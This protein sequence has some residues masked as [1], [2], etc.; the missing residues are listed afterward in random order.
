M[1]QKTLKLQAPS[2]ARRWLIA[3]GVYNL[4]W[5]GLVILFPH[6][7]FDLTGAERMRYPE[8]WQC[9]GMIVGVYGIGYI[10]ASTNPRQHWPIILVGLLGKVFGPIG[11]AFAL[12]KGTFPPS[13]G[14]TI[15]TND[16]IWWA[17]FFMILWD[18]FRSRTPHP[19]GQTPT[20]DSA[21][22]SLQDQH[23]RTLADTTE[24]SPTLVVLLRHS[25]CTFCKEA[26]ADLAS[27]HTN[28]ADS[29]VRLAIVT[30]SSPEQNA[31]LAERYRLFDA[32]WLSDPQRLLYRALEL[33]RGTFL[34]LFGP[35]V[36]LRG[37]AATLR[38][39]IVGGLDGDGLQMPGTFLLHRRQVLRGYRHTNAADRP[40]Y[41][42]LACGISD[43]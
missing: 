20:L 18:T 28:I 34:Q 38:G 26:L 4:L 39:H 10:I 37:I 11:F 35:R 15:L 23:Q 22:E 42:K 12:T 3:A 33:R 36:V 21:L 17:P 30:M 1:E 25:G 2:W 41:T 43:A 9:V 40:D 19:T 16:L 27:K 7:L 32:A 24:T 13:F 6:L 31:K 8:I 5:G 14:L 29:G